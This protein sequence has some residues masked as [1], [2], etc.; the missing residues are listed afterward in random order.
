MVMM[1]LPMQTGKL[2]RSG[3][4][5]TSLYLLLTWTIVTD[6]TALSSFLIDQSTIKIANHWRQE[7]GEPEL[8]LADLTSADQPVP[9]NQ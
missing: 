3:F 5:N 7:R 2:T 9:A 6:L 8:R 1:S 4:A